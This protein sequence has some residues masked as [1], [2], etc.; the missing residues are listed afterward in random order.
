MKH[1]FF[2]CGQQICD[3]IP[4]KPA[5]VGNRANV[6]NDANFWKNNCLLVIASIVNR[7]HGQIS[8][9]PNETNLP[10]ILLLHLSNEHIEC[11]KFRHWL[12]V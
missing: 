11:P 7:G 2:C 12:F 9:L 6:I 5:S 10:V 3:F 4:K 1:N 8:P